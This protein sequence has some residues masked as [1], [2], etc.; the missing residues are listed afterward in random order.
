VLNA[1]LNFQDLKCSLKSFEI[2][3]ISVVLDETLAVFLETLDLI[4]NAGHLVHELLD[5]G[6]NSVNLIRHHRS[7][8]VLLGSLL[9]HGGMVTH[10]RMPGSEALDLRNYAGKVRD[11]GVILGHTDL[12][13]VLE[14]VG[15]L[16]DVECLHALLNAKEQLLLS[17]LSLLLGHL[18]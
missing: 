4:V 12:D 13:S 3:L 7:D 10:A 14:L 5:E 15:E 6:T 17:G 2:K 16:L 9:C 18:G 11:K 8:V 1:L